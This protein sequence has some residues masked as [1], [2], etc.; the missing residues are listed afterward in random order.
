MSANVTLQ[1]TREMS[2]TYDLSPRELQI[3]QGYAA[4]DTYHVI[5]KDLCIAPS[6]VRTPPRNDIPK[7]RSLS[8]SRAFGAAARRRHRGA[9][10]YRDGGDPCG[11]RLEP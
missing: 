4:G 2:D 7:A 11:T 10:P 8:K 1:K 9:R 5:A 3:A 6:T